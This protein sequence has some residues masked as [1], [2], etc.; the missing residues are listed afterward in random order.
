MPEPLA[1]SVDFGSSNTVALLRDAKGQ[2]R[3]LLFDGSPLLPSA[4]FAAPD[5][6]LLVGRDA[7]HLSRDD[8]A[9]FEP[10][11][12]RRIDDGTVL[13]GDRA[14]A[15]ADLIAA[16][17]RR[18]ADEARRVAGVL[19]PAVLTHPVAWGPARRGVLAEAAR[20]AGLPVAGMVAEPIAAAC[21]FTAVLGS[22]LA[23]GQGLAVFDFGGG[24]LDVAVVRRAG[25]QLVVAATG[26]LDT[27]GGIDIDAA[28]I[29]HLAGSIQR[30][31]P[32]LWARLTTPRSPTDLRDRALV[33]QDARAAKEILSRASQAGVHVPGLPT[34]THLTRGEFEE[35]ATPLVRSA[36][37]ETAGTIGRSG[38]PAGALAGIF[39]V[40][41]SS[42][43]PLVG[44]ALHRALGV[45]P[46]VLEQ[47]ETA[48]A[49]G[50][51]H[52]PAAPAL[53]PRVA[54]AMDRLDPGI[55][56]PQ[57]EPAPEVPARRRRWLPLVAA[58]AFLLAAGTTAVLLQPWEKFGASA[59]PSDSPSADPTRAAG[60]ARSASASPSPS[61]P[62]PSNEQV[63]RSVSGSTNGGGGTT[64]GANFAVH[65]N[66]VCAGGFA[67][68]HLFGQSGG[69]A[70]DPAVA[71]LQYQNGKWIQ[72]VLGTSICEPGPDGGQPDW[73]NGQQVPDKVMKSVGC[74]PKYYN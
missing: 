39:L 40:G 7:A 5:G 74:D 31:A 68:V 18:V 21:Y 2:A 20:R 17:L 54:Q 35:L 14:V 49:E 36:V 62:C 3:T 61:D 13:L 32:D 65:G 60:G 69:Q 56:V 44:Q 24:T 23:A 66:I 67:G 52:S 73:T 12:K 59:G 72:L 64:D 38:T 41:G 55:T 51:L 25:G 29:G 6:T 58:A 4:V 1:L 16:V 37:A 70:N 30:Q 26:G 42:R 46:T 11:P 22:R 33:W 15:V 48:V 50:A 45:A 28:I 57:P 71:V 47:P 53:S 8:P 9:R 27:V 63:Q 10:H 19:P 43:I 34:A